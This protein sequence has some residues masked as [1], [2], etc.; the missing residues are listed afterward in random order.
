LGASTRSHTVCR[1]PP[2]ELAQDDDGGDGVREHCGELTQRGVRQRRVPQLSG[3]AGSLAVGVLS[4][5]AGPSP[6]SWWWPP[7]AG[8]APRSV[9]T[10]ARRCA[11]RSPPPRPRPPPRRGTT[12][13][14]AATPPASRPTSRRPLGRRRRRPVRRRPFPRSRLSAASELPPVT[15]T[16]RGRAGAGHG[17]PRSAWARRRRPRGVGAVFAERGGGWGPGRGM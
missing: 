11:N 4:S 17:F 6:P 3:E 14:R 12:R 16:T 8:P 7:R 1:C 9:R 2:G 5:G 13:P 10:G 15:S